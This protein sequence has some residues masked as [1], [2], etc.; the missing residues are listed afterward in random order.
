MERFRSRLG[1]T[2]IE[3]LVVIAIIAILIGLLLP[4]V[5][6]VRE[7]SMR[8]SCQNNLKQIG[9]AAH[10]YHGVL[11][12]FPPGCS[13]QHDAW[14]QSPQTLL[15]PYMEQSSIYQSFDITQG[16]YAAVNTAAIAQKPKIYL[17]PS[18]LQQ[19][20]STPFGFTNYHANSGSWRVS[21][22]GWD[23]VFGTQIAYGGQPATPN[24]SVVSIAD[25]TSNTTLFAEV[26]NGPYDGSTPKHPL[27][28]CFDGGTIPTT[29]AAARTAL[30]AK[31]WS[32]SNIAGGGTWRYRGYPWAEANIWRGWYNHLLPP[33]SP[34]WYTNGDWWNLVTPSSSFHPGGANCCMA[35]GSVRFVTET[36][37]ALIWQA[38]GTR[39]GG[40][41]T[42]LP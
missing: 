32:A 31:S 30:L 15:L 17:C 42:Q 22:G 10:N 35:D 38:T 33:N 3:L 37:D 4:A 36:I 9:L 18:D 39:A 27:R 12:S 16:V 13:L 28:D 40:E 25:G 7:A 20:L 24:V 6:K 5:Q 19:G 1:F 41:A 11:R 21:A 29:A 8:M 23:G 2:L 26:C 14:G 34:C